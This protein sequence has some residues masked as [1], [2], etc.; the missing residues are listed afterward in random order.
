[1]SSEKHL[2]GDPRELS[3]FEVLLTYARSAT[4]ISELRSP[5]PDTLAGHCGHHPSCTRKVGCLPPCSAAK[6][7]RR[8]LVGSLSRVSWTVS[9]YPDARRMSW[10]FLPGWTP[11]CLRSEERR[12]GKESRSR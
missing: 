11:S 2:D 5:T 12:V 4:V 9:G 6:D 8:D 10:N 1:M 3:E 7:R